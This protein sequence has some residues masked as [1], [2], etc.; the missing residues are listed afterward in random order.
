MRSGYR[1]FDFVEVRERGHKKNEKQT[2]QCVS[3]L[4]ERALIL[5]GGL[6]RL[7]A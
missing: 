4:N 6:P 5:S 3:P 2:E 1:R 7:S